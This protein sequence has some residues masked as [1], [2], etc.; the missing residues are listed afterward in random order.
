MSVSTSASW[1]WGE[2]CTRRSRRLGAAV[3]V[4]QSQVKGLRASSSSVCVPASAVVGVGATAGVGVG[5]RAGAATVDLFLL[6]LLLFRV[7][8][9]VVAVAV[10]VGS[11]GEAE[12]S[13]IARRLTFAGAAGK[14]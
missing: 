5:A 2:A 6:L 12:R 1:H 13:L 14:G 11:V 3:W 10:V 9:V 7:R 4:Q 8:S